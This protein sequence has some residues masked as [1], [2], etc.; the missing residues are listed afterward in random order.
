MQD[1]YVLFFVIGCSGGWSTVLRTS[2]NG[3]AITG[4]KRDLVDRLVA[5]DDIRISFNEQTY[6]T[7]IQS[8]TLTENDNVCVQAL[9]QLSRSLSNTDFDS[10]IHWEFLIVCTTGHLHVSKWSV[11]EHVNRGRETGRADI[12]WY[13]R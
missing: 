1:P 4:R 12:E 7:S 8:A 3:T 9:F 10:D 5:G 13:V 6:F 2:T 11:G